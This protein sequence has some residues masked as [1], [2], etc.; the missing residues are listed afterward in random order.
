MC[1]YAS[2][3]HDQPWAASKERDFNLNKHPLAQNMA[4]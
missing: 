1:D 2:H 4:N 3:F